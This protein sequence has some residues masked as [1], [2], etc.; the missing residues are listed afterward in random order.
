[1]NVERQR[2]PYSIYNVHGSLVQQTADHV[3]DVN[4]FEWVRKIQFSLIISVTINVEHSITMLWMYCIVRPI[5][6]QKV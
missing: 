4:T 3:D 5:T 1:M 2:A 6:G